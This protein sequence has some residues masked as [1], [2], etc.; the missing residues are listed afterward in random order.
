MLPLAM[1]AP[2][3]QLIIDTDIGAFVDDVGAICTA[4]AL[5]DLGEADI[6]AVV[7]D[8]GFIKGVGGISAL[9]GYYGHAKTMLGAYK[10]IFGR[11]PVHGNF[12]QDG[13][14]S[15]LIDRFTPPITN[16]TQVPTA[17]EVYRRALARAPDGS[18]RIASIG[19]TTNLH[20]LMVSG[21][22]E[23]S[24]LHGKDLVARKVNT[25]AWMDGLYNFGCGEH[26]KPGG[27]YLGSDAG[28]RGS[29]AAA[30][31]DVVPHIQQLFVSPDVCRPIVSGD[32][33]TRCSTAANPC[34]RAYLDAVG[35][36]HGFS[37]CDSMTV[38]AA[39]RGAEAAHLKVSEPAGK[40]TI[41]QGG[42]ER[43]V[44]TQGAPSNQSRLVLRGNPKASADSISR[45]INALLCR[46]P[47]KSHIQPIGTALP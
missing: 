33:L 3:P 5:Q 19:M 43:W 24:P 18:V 1:T 29:A 42:E 11:E 25:V 38:L 6:I 37:S 23:H 14:L 8:T 35:E 39:V 4:N 17:L 47:H 15:D 41:A 7:H 44:P 32:R 46:P 21:P 9:L 10:G 20:D 13:F 27:G 28:C 45:D 40:L 30:V 26:D 22:D 2:T 36:D 16:A 34:R 31:T 12:S